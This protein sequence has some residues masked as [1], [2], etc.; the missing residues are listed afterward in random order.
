MSKTREITD[1]SESEKTTD[2]CI[3]KSGVLLRK[4]SPEAREHLFEELAKKP[5]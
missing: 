3:E 4:L 2:E 1:Y 5:L